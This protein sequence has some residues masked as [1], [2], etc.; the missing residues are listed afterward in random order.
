MRIITPVVAAAIFAAALIISYMHT[1]EL[2]NSAGLSGMLAHLGVA[3]FELSFALGTLSLVFDSAPRVAALVS[4][5]LG[6]SVVAAAN[7]MSGVSHGTPGVAIG[8]AIPAAV[9][10]A[11]VLLKGSLRH[12]DTEAAATQTRVAFERHTVTSDDDIPATPKVPMIAE[13]DMPAD[14]PTDK[15]LPLSPAKVTPDLTVAERRALIATRRAAGV[16]V[17]DIATELSVSART[18]HRDMAAIG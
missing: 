5:A 14:M 1:Y 4:I 13:T 17:A 10:V 9:V 7:V 2:M 12:T 15:A 6:L 11:E 18:V 8:L 3:T 16:P